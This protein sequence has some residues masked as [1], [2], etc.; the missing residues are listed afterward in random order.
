MSH[1]RTLFDDL[2]FPSGGLAEEIDAVR[3]QT[4]VAPTTAPETLDDVEFLFLYPDAPP[5]AAD[6][7]E[8]AAELGTEMA[9][10]VVEFPEIIDASDERP[11]TV[12]AAL[13][14]DFLFAFDQC[15]GDGEDEGGRASIALDGAVETSKETA[16]HDPDVDG[17]SVA[18]EFPPLTI[19]VGKRQELEHEIGKL[20][21][22]LERHRSMLLELREG[23]N[24][25]LPATL[26]R[27]A[28]GGL[29]PA[30]LDGPVEHQVDFRDSERFRAALPKLSVLL[31]LETGGTLLQHVD[32]AA[33][34]NFRA[35]APIGRPRERRLAIPES[36]DSST[37]PA[38]RPAAE[39]V[40]EVEA[41]IERVTDEIVVPVR[42]WNAIPAIGVFVALTAAFGFVAF[43]MVGQI[44][45]RATLQDALHS[46]PI[47]VPDLEVKLADANGTFLSRFDGRFD[48]V[49]ARVQDFV[50]V[51]HNA[52]E[53]LT[54]RRLIDP[55]VLK[56][57]DRAVERTPAVGWHRLTRASLAAAASTDDADASWKAADAGRIDDPL[58][59]EALGDHYRMVGRPE[60]A[61]A[62]FANVLRR[63][64]DRSR[65]VLAMLAEVRIDVVRSLAIVPPEP[66]AALQAALFVRNE[67]GRRDWRDHAETLLERL[68]TPR[69]TEDG[70]DLAARGQLQ[71]LLGRT[72][73]AADSYE[74]ALAKGAE[75]NDFR[76]ALAKLRYDQQ[77]FKECGAL[78][79]RI[80]QS[81]PAS[82]F[83][84][85]ARVLRNKIELATS[86]GRRP[87]PSRAAN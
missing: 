10:G 79:D 49:R 61:L 23:A 53:L 66:V 30:T 20:R 27:R 6:E 1:S 32:A 85:E 29:L 8:A 19:P 14:N 68:G 34:P 50:N 7:D 69:K 31:G 62:M 17:V 56:L 57:V 58:Y 42:W 40:D 47:R 84:E 74:R 25:F 82:G 77:R 63:R 45:A 87:R 52:Q 78:A 55:R 36:T 2:E 41:P 39:E 26:S 38:L 11:R 54:T 83:G 22:D 71:L 15:D 80:I 67:E 48:Y 86:G 51:K 73:D 75:R 5:T 16:G 76:L 44:N 64:P 18:D 46:A 33:E 24:P 72:D 13:A 37:L 65:D 3:D 4:R 70:D 28:A 21:R 60:D 81:D 43:G 9:S 59:W 35:L 12:E